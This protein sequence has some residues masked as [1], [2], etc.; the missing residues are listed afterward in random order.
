MAEA[1]GRPYATVQKARYRLGLPGVSRGIRQARRTHCTH[2]HEYDSENTIWTNGARI[3]RTCKRTRDIRRYCK[4]CEAGISHTFSHGTW[5]GYNYH[6]CRCAECCQKERDWSTEYYWRD[7]DRSLEQKR[8]S[9]E[10][11]RPERRR[12]DADP[13]RRRSRYMSARQKRIEAS[14]PVTRKGAWSPHE[15]ALVLRDD[16]TILEIAYMLQRTPATVSAQRSW[17]RNGGDINLA[18]GKRSVETHC[19]RRGHLL[20]EANTGFDQKTG[21]RRCKQCCAE[22]QRVRRG[23]Q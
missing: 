4:R 12:R 22:R 15:R 20:D 3:C 2:G 19:R 5:T 17:L 14:V 1:L 23:F 6:K 7:H 10:R 11:L 18:P 9:D 13:E 21:K 16:L 8:R